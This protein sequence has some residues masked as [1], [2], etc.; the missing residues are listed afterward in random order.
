MYIECPK[1]GYH[2]DMD[3]ALIPSDTATLICPKCQARFSLQSLAEKRETERREQLRE[4]FLPDP[5][6]EAQPGASFEDRADTCALAEKGVVHE[7]ERQP[8][9]GVLFRAVSECFLSPRN[10][11][12]RLPHS[13]GYGM[14]ILF[15]VCVSLIPMLA[16]L[17]VTLFRVCL[18]EGLTVQR[19]L[20]VLMSFGLT[21][22]LGMLST[23][24]ALF[25]ESAI[26]H[27]IFRMVH[28]G[29]GDF[30]VTFRMFSYNSAMLFCGMAGN[31]LMMFP[32]LCA[33]FIGV[34][35][36]FVGIVYMVGGVRHVR[37]SS[38]GRAWVACLLLPGL[39][40]I[41]LGLVL[42]ICRI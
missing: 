31:L 5:P 1:C 11:F 13:G 20:A 38:L 14:P 2:K 16:M 10:F 42:S 21:L 29:E 26:Y 37:R 19:L 7:W 32:S 3:A 40:G 34:G 27:A 22:V 36:V 12:S 6:P 33:K 17:A 30:Q 24:V 15:Y 9:P 4:D 39:L 18:G 8:S 35:F 41:V 28:A 23:V 25:V